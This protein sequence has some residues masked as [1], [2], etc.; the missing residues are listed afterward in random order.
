MFETPSKLH[1]WSLDLTKPL[2]LTILSPDEEERASRMKNALAQQCFLNTRTA[3]RCVLAAY[4][5]CFA[6][7][8]VFDYNPSGKPFIEGNPYSFN[9]SHSKDLALIGISTVEAIGIDLEYLKP[10]STM[11]AIVRRFFSDSEKEQ[12]LSLPDKEGLLFFYQA[13]TKKEALAKAKGLSIFH[14][15][16]DDP[17]SD[18]ISQVG[19]VS[20]PLTVPEGYLA[21][22]T[23]SAPL[24]EIESFSIQEHDIASLAIGSFDPL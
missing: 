14:V 24:E 11:T 9:L 7:E 1:V 23:A 10:L 16:K 15:L 19:W 8:I 17:S 5:G 4:L 3:L 13:W 21:T 6:K 2:P 18:T 22:Y 20:G 12:F